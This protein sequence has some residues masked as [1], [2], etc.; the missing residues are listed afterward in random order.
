M[1]DSSPSCADDDGPVGL[2]QAGL[3]PGNTVGVTPTVL[4]R[5]RAGDTRAGDSVVVFRW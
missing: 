2:L 1:T 5:I 4:G 3:D